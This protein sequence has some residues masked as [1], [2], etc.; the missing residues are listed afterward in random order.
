MKRI[1][2]IVWFVSLLLGGS[3]LFAQKVT[4][5][6]VSAIPDENPQEMLR[7]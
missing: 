6:K 1:A 7:I 4:E 5:L 3:E 2:V